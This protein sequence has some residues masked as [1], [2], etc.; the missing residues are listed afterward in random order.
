[1]SNSKLKLKHANIEI[2][3]A[4]MINGSLWNDSNQSHIIESATE[5]HLSS[6]SK[7][8]VDEPSNE[9]PC[10]EIS[11]SNTDSEKDKDPEDEEEKIEV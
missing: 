10:I 7:E 9:V 6:R 1:M 8:K 4:I 3:M 11:D 2:L 5:F